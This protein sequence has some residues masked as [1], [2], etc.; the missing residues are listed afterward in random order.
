MELPSRIG[1][2]ARSRRLGSR[3]RNC[4]RYK[5]RSCWRTRVSMAFFGNGRRRS[6]AWS[7]SLSSGDAFSVLTV[8]SRRPTTHFSTSWVIAMMRSFR[9]TYLSALLC[10]ALAA[11][12]FC[13]LRI[14]KQGI[15]TRNGRGHADRSSTVV[16]CRLGRPAWVGS[17]ERYHLPA[18]APPSTCSTSPVT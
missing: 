15:Q 18:C 3:S 14:T 4:R 12:V 13:R 2:N 9:A 17:L 1:A 8:A 11:N 10:V 7:I 5:P 16:P 6:D